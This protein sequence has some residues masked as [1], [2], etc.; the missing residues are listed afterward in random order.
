MTGTTR[1]AEH[2][3]HTSG[4]KA[5]WDRGGFWRAVLLGLMYLAVNLGTAQSVAWLVPGAYDASDVYASPGSVFWALVMPLAMGIVFLLVFGASV[6]WLSR[7]FARQ[8]IGGAWWMWILPL[9][10]LAG[11]ALHYATIDYSAFAAG[12]V[13]MMLVMGLCV[14][15]AEEILSRG[16]FINMLRAGGHQEL[17]VALLS[18][19]LFMAMHLIDV[20]NGLNLI[21]V[22]GLLLYTVAFGVAMYMALRV[23]RHLIWPVI[24]HASTDPATL[25][26]NAHH[27]DSS[28]AGIAALGNWPVIFGALILVWFVRGRVDARA[29]RAG[30][31]D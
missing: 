19:L 22:I 5:F 15:L 9:I 26:F 30:D 10:V 24:F 20:L 13:P 4:W 6:G 27:V 29:A 17:V 1:T 7:L 12:V 31:E 11:N 25:L 8:P 21:G 14:G 3:T 23:T 18:S 28:L 16:Y 2:R